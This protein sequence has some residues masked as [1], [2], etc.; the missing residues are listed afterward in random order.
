MNPEIS[1]IMSIRNESKS[2]NKSISSVLCQTFSNFEF[3]IIDDHSTDES[4][5]ILKKIKDKRIKLFKN[6]K[7]LGLTKSL[8]NLIDESKGN[9]IARIDADDFYYPTKLEKQLNFFIKNKQIG[10]C[11]SCCEIINELGDVLY[12]LCPSHNEKCL[13]WNLIFRNNIRHSSVMWQKELNK[14]YNEK[15]IQSQDYELWCRMIR[16]KVPI[17]IITENT[18]QITHRQNSITNKYS[19]SQETSACIVTQLQLKFY[20]KKR[21]PFNQARNLRL[22][23][24]QKSHLQSMLF[25]KLSLD[26]LKRSVSLY[27]DLAAA[28][29]KKENIPASE[30]IGEINSDLR[31]LLSSNYSNAILIEIFKWFNNNEKNEFIDMIQENFLK[32]KNENFKI[33]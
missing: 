24:F 13:K 17:G 2:L 15:F 11:A 32:I 14:K 28:F 1:V 12:C 33:F 26:E 19:T 6:K 21:I 4:F 27:L 29:Y 30:L 31:F 3:L 20:L 5:E 25:N 7:N 10:M 8:N 9:Y 22:M 16:E 18:T 23:C